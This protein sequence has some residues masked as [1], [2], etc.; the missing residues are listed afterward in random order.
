MSGRRSVACGWRAGVLA[1]AVL[2]AGCAAGPDYRRPELSSPDRYTRA[3]LPAAIGA[4][5]THDAQR[6]IQG[7]PVSREW[8]RGFGSPALDDLVR[9]ALVHNPTV[10]AAQAA[11][12]Q[13]EEEVAAQR[14]SYF[15]TIQASYSPSRSLN[16]VGT[17]SPTLSSGQALYTLHT[18]QLTVGYVP[19]VFGLNRRTVESLRAQADMQRDQLDATYLTLAAN[20]VDTAIQEASLQAQIDAT[21]AAIGADAR[22]L[23]I[24]RRQAAMGGASGLDVAAQ[25][26]ALAQA[27]Q[28]LPVLRKALE[29]TRDLLAVLVGA[30]PS[31]AGQADIDLAA[32]RLP[33]ALPLSL[34][35]QV[36]RQRPDV[37][38]AEA[39]VH[40]A[41]AEVGIAVANRLPQFSISAQYGGS[42]TQFSRMFTDDNVFWSLAGTVSQTLFDF[43]ALK[44]RQRAAEAALDQAKAQYRSVVLAAFQNVADT[45]YALDQ[46]SSVLAA[47]TQAEAA[48]RK[49]R[50]LTQRQ[51]QAGA[52]NALVLLGAEQAFQQARIARIQAVAARYEDTVALYQSMGTG[53][54]SPGNEGRPSGMP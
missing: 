20:V 28:N 35:S 23:S 18:A 36:I 21:K 12:R 46:D 44:H 17:I 52:V 26:A 7:A 25:A 22:A 15:P 16:P 32:L 43:G 39:Q 47:A 45:L 48:T 6:F 2:G 10:D 53:W 3:P 14:A 34:P 5:A 9:R 8:W 13:A 30:L 31:Q 33:A 38:A 42:S 41:S 49:T 54:G 11:L 37:L 40:A 50:D 51:L 27:R 29:Q 24:L 19:D 4:A 1:L